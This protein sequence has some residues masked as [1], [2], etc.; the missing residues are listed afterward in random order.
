MT[1][2]PIIKSTIGFAVYGVLPTT[3]KTLFS[4]YCFF[5]AR[6]MFDNL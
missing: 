2:K 4:N 6:R 3:F 5:Y 1:L